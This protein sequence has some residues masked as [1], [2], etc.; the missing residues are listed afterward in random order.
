MSPNIKYR[1]EAKAAISKAK[2]NEPGRSII[3]DTARVERSRA[4]PIGSG[5]VVS[6]GRNKLEGFPA[7]VLNFLSRKTGYVFSPVP[8]AESTTSTRPSTTNNKH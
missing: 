1:P 3:K 2:K 7:R 8:P 6:G 4:T 5:G